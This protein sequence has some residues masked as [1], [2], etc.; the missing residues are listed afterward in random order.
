[1]IIF[2]TAAAISDYL[3]FQ[4]QKGKKT[5]FVPT[6]GALHAGHLSLIARSRKKN[7]I[8]VCSIFI[9]PTQF[10][11]QQDF[12]LYPV[13]LEKD[14][15]VLVQS[16]CDVLFLPS[17]S[18]IYPAG[19]SKKYYPLGDIESIL[20]GAY[21]PGHFQGVCEVVDRLFEIVH[22]QDLYLGQKDFQQCMVIKELIGITGN[23]KKIALHIVPTVREKDGLAMSSRNLRLSPADREKA[24]EINLVLK[25][26]QANF[27][28]LKSG[29]LEKT[30]AEKLSAKGFVVDY[31]SI[32][33]AETLG[34]VNPKKGKAVALIAAAISE[35]RLIDNLV[36][37]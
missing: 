24:R 36:L 26:M 1:M 5:G 12:R 8:T 14:I 35:I 37:Q 29:D 13:T 6:M 17:V 4:Q 30:A 3:H 28:K 33:D 32:R 11:N 18:E 16:G 2:K 9:N 19:Y 25:F 31:V 20:E 34:E 23:K 7:D 27:K 21:R 22:P 15:D 10:N